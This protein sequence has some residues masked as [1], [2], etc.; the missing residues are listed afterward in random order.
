[1]SDRFLDALKDFPD[2]PEYEPH[3]EIQLP[4]GTYLTY[5]LKHGETIRAALSKPPAADNRG[6]DVEKAAEILMEF[7]QEEGK[8]D[9]QWY[10][11]EHADDDGYR[12]DKAWVR[13]APKDIQER[14]RDRV[15]A[16]NARALSKPPVQNSPQA[17]GESHAHPASMNQHG[18]PVDVQDGG[19]LF[20]AVDGVTALKATRPGM[21]NPAVQPDKDLK[22]LRGNL[23]S[24]KELRGRELPDPSKD[25]VW[26]VICQSIGVVNRLLTDK[27]GVENG[28]S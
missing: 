14:Y 11:P 27:T 9:S 19:D 4:I 21:F 23:E 17:S 24:I 15:K 28:F 25:V 22:F 26:L 5:F 8:I 2:P 16:L 20:K 7:D 1:M 6:V 12:G 18:A 13:L 3:G 10:W